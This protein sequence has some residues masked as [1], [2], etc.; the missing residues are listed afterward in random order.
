M[1]SNQGALL[2]I[3]RNKVTKA[4]RAANK[5]NQ[6]QQICFN[7]PKGKRRMNNS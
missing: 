3:Y 2:R 1:S 7:I 6:E 5:Q 4:L